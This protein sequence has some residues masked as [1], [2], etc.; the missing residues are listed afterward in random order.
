MGEDPEHF[1]GKDAYEH[2]LEKRAR[3]AGEVH[4]DELSDHAGA[5][6]E[7]VGETWILFL[8][9]SALF[10]FFPLS[11]RKAVIL[12]IVF[13]FAWVLWRGV[14]IARAGWARLERL[15]RVLE[16]ER[17]EIE[18]HREQER[19]ELTALYAMKG[20]KPPLLEEV[21]DVLMADDD[22]LLRVMM[23]EE[24]GL[25]PENYEHPLKQA[26]FAAAGVFLPSFL[27][28]LAYYQFPVR[29]PAF[30]GIAGFALSG[31]ITARLQKNNAMHAFVW[32]AASA[33]LIYG[34]TYFLTDWLTGYSV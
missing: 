18:N 8:I 11:D 25:Y 22:R 26:L 12:F 16:E 24:M 13:V 7:S 33:A 2:V 28:F 34:C 6:F 32:H 20:L 9:F 14:R 17:Y 21:I 3:V 10:A 29:G 4:G 15:H 31:W 19:E 30:C 27:L 23:E 5:F 1:Q